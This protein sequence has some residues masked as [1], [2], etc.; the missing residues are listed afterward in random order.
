MVEA[1]SLWHQAYELKKP[2]TRP[3]NS[4]CYAIRPPQ[5]L[6]NASD[7]AIPALSKSYHDT[8]K[9]KKGTTLLN[10]VEV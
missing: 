10:S 9:T 7:N 2:A 3:K 8:V 5:K 4:S 6:K 1:S